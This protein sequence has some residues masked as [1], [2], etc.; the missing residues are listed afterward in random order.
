M[1]SMKSM[2]KGGI[3]KRDDI[4]EKLYV[5]FDIHE[6][7]FTGT[8]MNKKGIVEFSGNVPNDKD[9]VMCFLSGIPSPQVEIAI[10]ACGLWRGVHKMLTDLGYLLHAQI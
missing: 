8:A 10:G 7:Y 6:D 2:K 5:G 9:A 3:M 1:K 4:K